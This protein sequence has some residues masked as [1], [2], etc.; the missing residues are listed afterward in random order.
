MPRSSQNRRT[1]SISS[2][3]R[4]VVVVE[5]GLVAE[6]PVPEEL[7]A[8]RVVG[9]VGL[10]GVHEDDPGERVLLVGVAPHVVVGVGPVGVAARLLEPGVR[11]GGVVH[12][13][14]GDDPDAALVRRV[15]QRDE[16]LDRAELRQ[17]LVEVA[18]VVAAVAQRRVVERRQ[19]QAVDAEPLQVVQLLDQPAQVALPVAVR[20]VERPDQHLVEDGALEPGLVVGQRPSRPKSLA[21]GVLDHAAGATWLPSARSCSTTST[22]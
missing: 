16:V 8:H 14:V 7:P 3:H 19:P 5:V 6:E 15:E 12:H 9:P 13:Q 1:L 4:R 17:H 22:R 21:C 10:L 20:V 2:L 18:D 11:V